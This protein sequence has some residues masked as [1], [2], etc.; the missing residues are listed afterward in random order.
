MSMIT[1]NWRPNR[2]ELRSFGDVSLAM[3][4]VIALLLCWWRGMAAQTGLIVCAAGLVIY[5]LSRISA[6]LVKPIY[7]VLQL[8]TLPIGWVMSYLVMGVFYYVVLTPVGLV[9]RLL[10][11]DALRLKYDGKA[12]TYWL[13]HRPSDSIKRYFNQF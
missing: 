6:K 2:D 7:I 3:L 1:M 4:T 5:V 12:A 8:A 13:D 11:R 10:G 9:F